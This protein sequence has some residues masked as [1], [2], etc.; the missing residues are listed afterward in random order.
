MSVHTF[1]WT[2]C[3]SAQLRSI[4]ERVRFRFSYVPALERHLDLVRSEVDSTEKNNNKKARTTRN[5]PSKKLTACCNCK[6]NTCS[7]GTP[8]I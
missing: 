3:V 4:G 5:H 7:F 8:L 1:F 6:R 2:S